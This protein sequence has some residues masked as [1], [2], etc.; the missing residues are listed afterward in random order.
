MQPKEPAWRHHNLP[1][2]D[3]SGGHPGLTQPLASYNEA[4]RICLDHHHT[5]LTELKVQ[6][7]TKRVQAMVEWEVTDERTRGSWVGE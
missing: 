5:S 6:N 7:G 1:L 4:A 3:M 2:I